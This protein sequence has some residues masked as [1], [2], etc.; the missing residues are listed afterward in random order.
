MLITQMA[1]VHAAA[2]SAMYKAGTQEHP[3]E[4]GEL[5]T[6]RAIRLIR[7]YMQQVEALSKLRSESGQ[8]R[9]VVEHVN[10]NAAG[11]AIVGVIAK[12][13][14]EEVKDGD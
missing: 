8:E 6:N 14:R 4:I 12:D 13:R 7:L 11:Q 9:L 10:V 5:Y 2:V 3:Y 1:G